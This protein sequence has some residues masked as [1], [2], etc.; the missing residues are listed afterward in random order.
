MGKYTGRHDGD[1][2]V[3]LV[4]ETGTQLKLAEEWKSGTCWLVFVQPNVRLSDIILF[5]GTSG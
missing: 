4:Q 2:D 5:I 3:L 1:R